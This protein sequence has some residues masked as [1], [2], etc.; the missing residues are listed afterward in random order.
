MAHRFGFSSAAGRSTRV[1]RMTLCIFVAY[2]RRSEKTRAR[3]TLGYAISGVLAVLLLSIVL[4]AVAA[5]QDGPVTG[6]PVAADRGGAE[7]I[8][9]VNRLAEVGTAEEI[10]FAPSVVN[11]LWRQGLRHFDF[12]DDDETWPIAQTDRVKTSIQSGEYEVLLNASDSFAIAGPEDLTPASFLLDT[13]AR[14]TA[15]TR[16][17]MVWSS[18]G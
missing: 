2:V 14:N 8:G 4:I 1:P 3:R 5:D 18:V 16:S 7:S 10:V 17:A 15:G 12:D 11:R 9:S 6:R 13:S